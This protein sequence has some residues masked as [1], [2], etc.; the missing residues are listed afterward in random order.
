MARAPIY[1][2]VYLITNKVTRKVYVGSTTATLARRWIQHCSAARNGSTY[3]LHTAIRSYGANAFKIKCIETVRGRFK[4]LKEAETRH[5]EARGCRAPKG[6]NRTVGYRGFDAACPLAE[7][8]LPEGSP[9]GKGVPLDPS[10]PGSSTFGGP[11][12]RKPEDRDESIFRI[13]DPDDMAKEQTVPDSADHGNFRVEEG[14]AGENISDKTKYP[15]RNDHPDAHNASSC[16]LARRFY[17]F[18]CPSHSGGQGGS[19]QG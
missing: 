1:G 19:Q 16:R 17:G 9:G 18:T 2:Y 7:S 4:A 5:I 6:Y 15:Y 11:G 3:A 10:I 12:G 13:R 14:G 8:G